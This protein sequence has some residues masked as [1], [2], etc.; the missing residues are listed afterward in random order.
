MFAH[1]LRSEGT[2][3]AQILPRVADLGS[4]LS[5]E[6]RAGAPSRAVLPKVH[7]AAS[8]SIAHPRRNNFG[9]LLRYHPDRNIFI[10]FAIM[11]LRRHLL[12]MLLGVIALAPTGSEGEEVPI[13][14][15]PIAAACAPTSD[16][17][18]GRP[19]HCSQ[20]LRM[21]RTHRTQC[22]HLQC[23]ARL[24]ADTYDS[25]RQL[26]ARCP[27]VNCDALSRWH[28]GGTV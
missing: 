17:R 8:V 28:G 1:F 12:L 15:R 27:G 6:N 22:C 26:D 14:S 4:I 13:P 19:H 21:Q 18:P 23:D 2:G 9:N 5:V 16:A 25:A 7:L 3:E 24:E 11:N 10:V 20:F